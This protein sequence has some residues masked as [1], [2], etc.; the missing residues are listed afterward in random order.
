MN[1]CPTTQLT[2]EERTTVLLVLTAS[3]LQARG[4]ISAS[5]YSPVNQKYA[6]Q[7]TAIIRKLGGDV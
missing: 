4:R 6:D 1:T 3:V 2:E 7:L 5:E